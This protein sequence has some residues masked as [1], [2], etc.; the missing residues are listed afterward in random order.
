MRIREEGEKKKR[1]KAEQNAADK[2]GGI[3]FYSSVLENTDS[4]CS[5]ENCSVVP[6]V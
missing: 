3:I 2:Q 1:E 5:V 4:L 6:E